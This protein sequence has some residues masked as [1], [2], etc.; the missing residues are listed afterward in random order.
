MSAARLA[1][2]A[3]RP[4]RALVHV[5]ANLREDGG[6]A[7]RLG[8]ALGRALRRYGARHGL[9]LAGL[10]LGADDGG[11]ALDG[12][13]SFGGG[14]SAFAA[15]VALRALRGGALW[16][17]H[18]GPAR[19]AGLLPAPA[20]ARYLVTLLGVD[21][22]RAPDGAG[23]RALA[24]ARAVVA[25]SRHT[26]ERAAPHLPASCRVEVV[27]PGLEDVRPGGVPDP[28]AL[29]AAGERFVLM[30]A[31][32]SAAERYK[33]HDELLEAW[34]ALTADAAADDRGPR[35]VLVGDGDDRERLATK[36]REL[37]LR[38]AARFT[39]AVD[40]ATL[41]EL[42]RRAA[43]FVLPSRDEGFGLVF[44][45]A[46]RA[47]RACLALAGTAPAEIVVEGETG[48][49][50]A[51]QEPP[52]LAAGLARLLADPERT[53]RLGAAGRARY[54]REFT[55]EAFERRLEPVLERLVGE[56]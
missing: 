56:G 33:G 28:T 30:V 40:A 17:D 49:L 24:H 21:A 38:D 5:S 13:R 37:G 12:Y 41:D 18:P 22:W 27:H 7:A 31:R 39:G 23:R 2:R 51:A 52:A 8:R 15:G 3:P 36:A 16:F 50:V 29:A 4:P 43:A 47:G 26:A 48:D 32:M 20:R 34:R 11:A 1:P 45:E 35:L 6:G 55:F 53:R 44:L 25:I 42:Y 46:M 54:E 19:V 9:R 14:R 10:H